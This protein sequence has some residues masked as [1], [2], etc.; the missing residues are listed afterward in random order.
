MVDKLRNL[1]FNRIVGNG[2]SSNDNM[3]SSCMRF[4]LFKSETGARE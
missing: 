2:I 3:L 1:G 4:M